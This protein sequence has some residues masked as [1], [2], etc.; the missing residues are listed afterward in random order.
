ME[1]VRRDLDGDTLTG[2]ARLIGNP[3]SKR[4]DVISCQTYGPIVCAVKSGGFH[5]LGLLESI[6]GFSEGSSMTL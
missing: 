2:V 5:R 4:A 1:L 3:N 6:Q